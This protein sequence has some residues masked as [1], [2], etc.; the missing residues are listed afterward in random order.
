MDVGVARVAHKAGERAVV[1]VPG[2]G[3]IVEIEGAAPR[4]R[5]CDRDLRAVERSSENSYLC[6]DGRARQDEKCE[7]SRNYVDCF[8]S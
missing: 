6:D 8:H 2:Q 3:G 7:G 5:A 4:A 1:K